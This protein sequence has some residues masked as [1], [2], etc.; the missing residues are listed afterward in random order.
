MTTKLNELCISIDKSDTLQYII[1]CSYYDTLETTLNKLKYEVYNIIKIV[2]KSI[3]I[4]NFD[5]FSIDYIDNVYQKYCHYTNK[6]IPCNFN[7]L[8]NVEGKKFIKFIKKYFETRMKNKFNDLY[9]YQNNTFD[10]K[11]KISLKSRLQNNEIK[12]YQTNPILSTFVNSEKN[13]RFI[14]SSNELL[15]YYKKKYSIELLKIKV[16]DILINIANRLNIS[17]KINTLSS[18]HLKTIIYQSNNNFII[19][20]SIHGLHFI[21]IIKEYIIP[22]TIDIKLDINRKINFQ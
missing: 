14:I 15:K 6:I 8:F 7:I 20:F 12:Y 21:N 2:A 9:I 22:E 17:N 13:R 10:N 5:S 18:Y 3:G 19:I 11:D 16:I 1:Q 4:I